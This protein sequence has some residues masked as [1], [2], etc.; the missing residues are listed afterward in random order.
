VVVE[1]GGGE[2]VV[3]CGDTCP[4]RENY[5]DRNITGI[6]HDPVKALDSIDALRELG[7]TPVFSHDSDQME[8]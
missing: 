8:L 2:R 1:L 4:V 6:L 7:G 3:Y 5:E